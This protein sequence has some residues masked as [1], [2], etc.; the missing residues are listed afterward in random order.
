VKR[1]TVVLVMLASG[2]AGALFAAQPAMAGIDGACASGRVCL[3]ENSNYNQNSGSTDHWA[4]FT[5]S[6]ADFA[7]GVWLN[8]RGELT[9]VVMNDETSSIKNRRGCSIH[10]YRH[11]NYVGA[12]ENDPFPTGT[13]S[14]NL[15]NRSVGNDRASS[16]R[17]TC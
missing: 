16:V 8:H 9:S 11:R 14:A 12:G 7:N 6:Y 3:Y 4:D 13:G 17:I 5:T 1:I 15:S 2:V 10:L